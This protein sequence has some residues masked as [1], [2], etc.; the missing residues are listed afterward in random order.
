MHLHMIGKKLGALTY[1]ILHGRWYQMQLQKQMQQNLRTRRTNASWY[2]L[3]GRAN[4]F[5]RNSLHGLT[6]GGES[7]LRYFRDAH[8]SVAPIKYIR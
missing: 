3:N 8:C 4:R 5:K 6:R 1:L 2:F 7:W